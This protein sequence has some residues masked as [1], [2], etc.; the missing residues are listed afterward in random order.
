LN[1]KLKKKPKKNLSDLDNDG[2][3]GPLTATS[4][5]LTTLHAI[6]TDFINYWQLVEVNIKQLLSL[7]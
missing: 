4:V 2:V 6:P 3:Q 5:V 7:S 1:P